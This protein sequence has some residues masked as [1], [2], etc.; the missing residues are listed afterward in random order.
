MSKRSAFWREHLQAWQAS[1]LSQA[2]Y[3]RQEGLCP[4]LFSHW[5]SRLAAEV[6]G[7][8][9]DEPSRPEGLSRRC[10]HRRINKLYDWL[11]NTGAPAALPRF[12]WP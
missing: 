6:Y 4:S 12:R 3:C 2:D 5:K 8:T 11:W 10:A 9:V 1:G 7:T